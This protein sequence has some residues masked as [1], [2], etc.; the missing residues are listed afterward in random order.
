MN[1]VAFIR[2]G[3]LK[4]IESLKC[5]FNCQMYNLFNGNKCMRKVIN[6]LK[7][8]IDLMG[9]I[10]V[11]ILQ[12]RIPCRL[13]WWHTNK[14]LELHN[15]LMLWYNANQIKTPW[16]EYNTNYEN[17]VKPINDTVQY[18]VKMHREQQWQAKIQG[19]LWTHKRYQAPSK[20][21]DHLS[22]YRDSHY[23]DET[24]INPY[25]L[26]NG[27]SILVRQHHYNEKAP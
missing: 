20:Y 13:I 24:V 27:I 4:G 23:K 10:M 5:I 16:I 21:K 14:W 19:I 22:W 2:L 11:L 15:I 18:N 12:G 8:F 7:L 6:I 25:H 9:M 17:T 26:W 3:F 1:D